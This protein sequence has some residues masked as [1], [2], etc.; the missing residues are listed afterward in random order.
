MRAG[1]V[2]PGPVDRPRAARLSSRTMIASPE[3]GSVVFRTRSTQEAELVKGI[4]EM[5]GIPV[6]LDSD[7]SP[8]LYPIGEMRLLVPS[9]AEDEAQRIL[10]G[11]RSTAGLLDA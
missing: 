10:A 8:G 4:F 2:R 7:I 1:P 11:H 9:A 5:Y 3:A 6:L